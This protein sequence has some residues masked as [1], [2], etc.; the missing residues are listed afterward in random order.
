M[1]VNAMCQGNEQDQLIKMLLEEACRQWCA[2]IDECPDRLTGEGFGDFFFEIYQ[3][4]YEEYAKELREIR[5]VMLPEGKPNENST[6]IE[7]D[8]EDTKD[9][10]ER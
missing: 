3:D 4:K 10:M 8:I 1:D 5:A 2:F 9:E 7:P 6:Y